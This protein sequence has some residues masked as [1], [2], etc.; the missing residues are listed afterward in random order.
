MPDEPIPPQP[1]PGQPMS[2]MAGAADPRPDHDETDGV[3]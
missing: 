3:A 2:G 1:E